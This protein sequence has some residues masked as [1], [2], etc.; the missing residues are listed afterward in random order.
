MDTSTTDGIV[1][2]AVGTGN[3]TTPLA[4]LAAFGS[5]NNA[6]FGA[7]ANTADSTTTP[8]AGFT[9]LSDLTTGTTP[10][11]FLQ[12]QWQV[13]NDTTSDG[14]ITSGQWGACAV[15]IKADASP[16]VIPPSMSGNPNVYMGMTV[17]GTTARIFRSVV[18]IEQMR[19]GGYLTLTS[20]FPLPSTVTPGVAATAI[21]PLAGF[22]SRSLIG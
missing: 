9:E 19:M 18:A 2:Q 16:F 17:S 7:N 3:S 11:S 12:T 22:S 14:T 8:G 21:V 20:T 6:T 10:A 4:T 13:G 1:Q 5:A 15:E